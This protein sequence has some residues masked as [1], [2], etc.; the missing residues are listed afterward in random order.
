ML[1]YG[2]A[3]KP[4]L[5]D[6]ADR[7]FNLSHTEGLLACAVSDREVGIDAER[8]RHFSPAIL[9]RLTQNERDFIE[10]DIEPEL[11]FIKVLTMKEAYIKLMGEGIAAFDRVECVPQEPMDGVI[12]R[13][14]IWQ[15]K[16]VITAM[17]WAKS[18]DREERYR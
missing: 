14:F 15:G 7:H 2:S 9:R 18:T 4:Y 6:Y 3:G 13:Q 12:Y 11:A 8:I 1:A 5:K 16:Y 17:T 10:S